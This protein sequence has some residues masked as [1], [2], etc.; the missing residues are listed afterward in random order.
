MLRPPSAKLNR[1]IS[2]MSSNTNKVTIYVRLLD[3]GM[4]VSRPTEA[5]D[6]KNGFFEILLTEKYDAA[7]ETWKEETWEISSRLHHSRQEDQ[8][9]S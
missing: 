9:K 8:S 3:E 7:E 6:L 5:V 1:F 2:P 4:E